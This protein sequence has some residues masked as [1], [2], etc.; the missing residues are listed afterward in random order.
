[1]FN[2]GSLFGG[3]GSSLGGSLGGAASSATGMGGLF[4]AIKSGEYGGLLTSPMLQGGLG[5]LGS[6]KGNE[7]ESLLGGI[8]R[9]KA[10][11]DGMGEG[12]SDPELQA[13]IAAEVE[14]RLAAMPNPYQVPQGGLPRMGNG[15]PYVPGISGYPGRK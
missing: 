1:M 15:L 5:L 12:D 6:T 7:M 10:M 14:K 4:D 2:L 8:N 3:L 11:K 9:S 13:M